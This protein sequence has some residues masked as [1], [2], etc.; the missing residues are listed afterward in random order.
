MKIILLSV[1]VSC[2]LFTCADAQSLSPSVVSTSGAFYSN[3]SGMLSSTI[4]ELTMVETF[5][6]GSAILNQ[7]FQQTFDFTTGIN[8]PVV[9]SGLSIYPNPTSG[10]VTVQLPSSFT[11]EV[12]T[13]IY[14][15]IGKLV[16]R[17]TE[18]LIGQSSTLNLTLENFI[19]GM[20]LVE[21][22]THSENFVTKINLIK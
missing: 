11:D 1:L 14:D 7:G 19:D 10:N 17:K 12:S 18:K 4:G 8:N 16:Y 21:V 15:A 13:S 5:S 9:S 22:K 2:I 6:N 20:Y 3:G